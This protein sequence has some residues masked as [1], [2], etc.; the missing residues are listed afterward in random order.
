MSP[1]P[2][3][4]K[5]ARYTTHRPD[6]TMRPTGPG[7]MVVF[8]PTRTRRGKLTYQEVD[9]FPYYKASNAEERTP[10]TKIPDAPSASQGTTSALQYDDLPGAG[11]FW[12][13]GNPQTS[14]R[15]KVSTYLMPWHAND[16][17]PL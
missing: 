2:R 11:D 9:A 12:E 16:M 15:T 14:R 6:G 13:D 5:R 3:K 10:R 4:S 17:Y 7:S 1:A 8:T